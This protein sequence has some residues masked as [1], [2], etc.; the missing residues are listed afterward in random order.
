MGEAGRMEVVHP[1]YPQIQTIWQSLGLQTA[2]TN[3]R[4]EPS[5]ELK[6]A[7]VLLSV[8]VD[9]ATL[10]AWLLRFGV[11][12][13]SRTFGESLVRPAFIHQDAQVES[14]LVIFS[15]GWSQAQQHLFLTH[16]YEGKPDIPA[17]LAPDF[18]PQ[19]AIGPYWR[20]DYWVP[21][22]MQRR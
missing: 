17:F 2:S 13:H 5:D 1:D 21:P 3:E 19:S 20:L 8:S 10:D 11:S 15:P 7:I 18:V 9:Q 14:T 22:A 16:T 12:N 4:I 6:K